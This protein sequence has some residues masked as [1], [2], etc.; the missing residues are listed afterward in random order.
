MLP[1]FLALTLFNLLCLSITTALGYGVSWG[2]AWGPWH[3]LAGAIATI[4]CC[5]VHCVV[6][7]YFVATSKWVRHAIVVK[8]LDPSLIAPTRSF[9]VR[10]FPAALIAMAIVFVAAVA[11]AAT[12]SYRLRPTT[13]HVLAL[14]SLATNAICAIV[15]YRAIAR[16]GRL[17]DTILADIVKRG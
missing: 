2:H 12:F 17:I 16:N 11:G 13:H 1:L 15:E 6:F 5:G 3:Q 7:T 4:I 8:N 14:L 9:K 10:A